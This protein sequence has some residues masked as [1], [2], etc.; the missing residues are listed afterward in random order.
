[1]SAFEHDTRV[2]EEGGKLLATFSRNWEIWGPNGGYVASIA[3]RAAG[4]VVPPDHR[5]ATFSCQ[6]LSVGQFADVEID[7]EPARKGRNAWCVNVVLRQGEKRILQAQI[8]TTNKSEGPAKIDRKWPGVALPQDLKTWS[9]LFPENKET[10]AFWWNFEGKPATVPARGKADPRGSVVQGWNRFLDFE[11][12][13][14]PF[15]DC[16]RALVMIDVHPWI[17]FGNGLKE[18]PDYVAPT[19]DLTA[20]FHALPGPFDWLLVDARADV[21]GGGLIHGSV[22]VWTEDGRIIASGGSNLLH[23]ARNQ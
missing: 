2:R 17:A 22:H 15:L 9:E 21:A 6:Y 20:W 13:H 14:D 3:L 10:F 7:A 11:H 5:P 4:K 18:R 12:T 19:L 1:M 16:A 8:W 23:V